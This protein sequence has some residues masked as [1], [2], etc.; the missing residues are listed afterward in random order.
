VLARFPTVRAAVI[1]DL[2]ADRFIYGEA[3]R[4]S[5]EAPVP[6]V[7][8][9]KRTIQPGGAANVASNVLS[10]GGKLVLFGVLGDDDAGRDVHRILEERGAEL[11]G[12]RLDARRPTTVK[13]RVVA[14]AQHLVRFDEEETGPIDGE[15]AAWLLERLGTLADTVNV[16]VF[17]DYAKGL[18]SRDLVA[19][20][21]AI[22]RERGLPIVADPKPVNIGL[23][24]GADVV[25]PNLGEALRLIGWEREP[26]Q[27]DMEEVCRRVHERSEARGVI[28]TAG[29][30]GMYIL[31]E[32]GFAHIPGTPREVYDVAG[33]G[34]STLAAIALGLACGASLRDAAHLG[35]LAGGIAVEKLGI[36]AVSAEEMLAEIGAE[37]EHA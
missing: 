35:N 4:L 13:T 3:R 12:V 1:G 9:R 10:L 24:S 37:H 25:K 23:Y 33:A 22:C 17:S 21:I 29:R 5:P 6:V 36:A 27:D 11:S 18:L 31:D 34:D 15:I 16:V 28:V 30:R 7:H 19:K 20:A 14:Q 26:A 8:I 2:M 32:H